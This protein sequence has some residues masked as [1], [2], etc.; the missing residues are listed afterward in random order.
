M[1]NLDW[2]HWYNEKCLYQAYG[3]ISQATQRKGISTIQNSQLKWL[4]SD[5]LQRLR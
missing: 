1:A 2:I 3:Y 4:L 5:K